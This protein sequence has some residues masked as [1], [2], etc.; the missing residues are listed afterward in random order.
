VGVAY[1]ASPEGVREFYNNYDL[2]VRIDPETGRWAPNS[3]ADLT[4]RENRFAHSPSF[5]HQ[6]QLA[7][8]RFADSAAESRTPLVPFGFMG[9]STIGGPDR[10][11]EDV[12]LTNA[13]AF[14]LRVYDPLAPLL[15]AEN[16]VVVEPSDIGWRM[17][18][19]NTTRQNIVNEIVGRG[20]YVDLA[21]MGD[22]TLRV[23][24]YEPADVTPIPPGSVTSQFS[25]APATRA[26][27]RMPPWIRSYYDTWSAHYEYDGLNQ[28]NLLDND[29]G[30][31]GVDDDDQNGVDDAGEHETSPPY[32][33]PLRGV[34]VKL[35][36]YEPASRAVREVSVKQDF[37]Q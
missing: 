7:L 23:G 19:A 10:R 31:N 9:P 22:P 25:M 32:P 24:T 35:R 37:T 20:A 15:N 8:I 21:Y 5:P 1:V 6:M 28:D 11:G 14:D 2:S 12:M 30:T 17:K 4:K 27:L 13:L 26:R 29:Q 34:E 18:L 36:V 16:A 33:S 3:L